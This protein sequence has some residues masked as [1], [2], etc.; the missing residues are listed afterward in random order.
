MDGTAT[1]AGELLDH[2]DALDP[3]ARRAMLDRARADCGMDSTGAVEARERAAQP[4]LTRT[5]GDM[6]LQACHAAGCATY[7]TTDAGSWRPVNVRRWF[8]PQHVD[9]AQPGDLDPPPPPYRLS[10]SGAL[11]PNDPVEEAREEAAAQSR[12][13]QLAAHDATRA[14][15]AVELVEHRAARDQAA[16]REL[17]AHLRVAV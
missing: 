13:N 14:V 1:T 10:P 17:P 16:E 8:C 7:P 9:Q 3:A 6:G 11:V 15:E 12:A 2:L 5:S 4:T